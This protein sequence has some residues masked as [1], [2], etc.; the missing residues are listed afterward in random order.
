MQDP[1]GAPFLCDTRGER[2]HKYSIRA[3]LMGHTNR[4]AEDYVEEGQH[5]KTTEDSSFA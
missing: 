4:I 1:G 5:K 2:V 3:R